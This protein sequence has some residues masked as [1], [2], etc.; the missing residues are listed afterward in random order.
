[1]FVISKPWH[2]DSNA[3]FFVG[4]CMGNTQFKVTMTC[5]RG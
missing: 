4:V 2:A 3:T 1:L 5:Y